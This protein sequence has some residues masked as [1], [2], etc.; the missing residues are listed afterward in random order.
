[1]WLLGI[2]LRTSG[3]AVGA[4]KTSHLSHPLKK[5]IVRNMRLIPELRIREARE[6]L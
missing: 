5:I 2:E 6:A 1:M 4:L 3:G